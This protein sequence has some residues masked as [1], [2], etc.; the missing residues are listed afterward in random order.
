[1]ARL[2][3]EGH[4][5]AVRGVCASPAIGRDTLSPPLA[6]CRPKHGLT[7]SVYGVPAIKAGWSNS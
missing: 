3:P 5:R 4:V 2:R 1:M 7:K 6:F